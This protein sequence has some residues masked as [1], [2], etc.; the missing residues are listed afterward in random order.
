MWFLHML[1]RR[2]SCQMSYVRK[3][4]NIYTIL[5]WGRAK[6]LRRFTLL[7]GIWFASLRSWAGLELREHE[8]NEAYMVN[9]M[10][11]LFTRPEEL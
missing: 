9:L 11:G 3:L 1:C 10:W 7:I 8:L 4:I 6:E 5:Y 2:R